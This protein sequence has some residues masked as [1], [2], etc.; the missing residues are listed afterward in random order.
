MSNETVQNPTEKLRMKSLCCRDLGVDCDFVS[1]GESDK[2]VI[3]SMFAHST[4]AHPEAYGYMFADKAAAL[5]ADME[6][7]IKDR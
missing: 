5:V 7:A 1:S 3:E 6:S 4:E 2:I